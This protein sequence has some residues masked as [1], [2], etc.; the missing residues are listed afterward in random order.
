[1]DPSITALL[2]RL[3]VSCQAHDGNPLRGPD[4]M[5]RMA[6]AA[7]IG[8]AGGIRA[9]GVADVR[10]IRAAVDAP[11]IGLIKTEQRDRDSVFITPGWDEASAVR[12]AGADVIALDGTPRP[13]PD[14]VPL[15]SLIRRIHDELG[16]PVMADIDSHASAEYAIEQG[17]DL[18]GTT[19]A[20]Y[21]AARP[22]TEGPDLEL[23]AEIATFASV[24]VVAEGR[25]WT[26]EDA[27][28]A[29]EAGASAV[30]VGTAIT[31]PMLTTARFARAVAERSGAVA[32]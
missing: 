14:G 27:I 10:A 1:M 28:A 12:A 11:I 5:A 15:G 26:R 22:A 19:L 29:I 7:I 21:T 17:C 2:G 23:V 31:N 16:C 3:V 9:E 32:G 8:G 20:G 25:F 6:Q 30:V 4:S 18:V 13:R 24:P